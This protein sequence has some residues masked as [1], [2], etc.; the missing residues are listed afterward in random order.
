MGPNFDDG[1]DIESPELAAAIN[2]GWW[3]MRQ[4]TI[5]GGD[6]MLVLEIKRKAPENGDGTRP[7]GG[8]L[9]YRRTYNAGEVEMLTQEIIRGHITEMAQRA[10]QEHPP[11]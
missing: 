10:L 9:S 5:R 4:W 8:W 6:V 3:L 2:A 1:A 11:G 7:P